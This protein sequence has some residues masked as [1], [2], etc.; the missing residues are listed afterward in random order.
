MHRAAPDFQV[1]QAPTHHPLYVAVSAVLSVVRLGRRPPA[2]AR[3]RAGVRR[4]RV[5]DLPRRRGGVRAVGRRRRGGAGA[6]QPDA[7]A[8]H[9][10]RVRRR[11]VRRLRDVGGGGRGARAT[12]ATARRDGA[13]RSSPGCCAP[14][15]GCWPASTGCGSAGGAGTCSRWRS[16]R[17]SG[18]R[19]STRSRPATRCTR[20]TPTSGQADQIERVR[21]L[22]HVPHELVTA[23]DSTVRAP[24]V[25]LGAGGRDRVRSS[26]GRAGANR[27]A[28]SR[29]RWRCSAAGSS[30]SRRPAWPG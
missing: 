16:P 4:A 2:R 6:R 27:A 18:G 29:C 21:G 26:C 5:G 1:Y 17:R 23:L 24:V 14:R 8:L 7:A 22:G 28:R 30:R 15:R 10:A 12:R 13:A 3:V 11:A 9:G 20:C 19:S 25:T